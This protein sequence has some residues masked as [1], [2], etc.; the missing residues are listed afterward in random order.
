MEEYEPH[1]KMGSIIYAGVDYG[2]ILRQAEEEADII[3][4]DG[5]NND[6]PF[7]RVDLGFCVVDPFR[8]GHE[9]RYWPGEANLRMADVVVINKVDTAPEDGLAKVRRNVAELY[10]E[11]LAPLPDVVTPAQPTTLP[12][13]MSNRST[14]CPNRISSRSRRS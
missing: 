1:I 11:R 12:A 6:L 9:L 3:I 2:A 7:Y 10:A 4:W 13:S 5:G 14:R 8:A